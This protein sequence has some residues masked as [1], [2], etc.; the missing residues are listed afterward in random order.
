MILIFLDEKLL[1]IEEFLAIYKDAKQDKEQGSAEEYLECLSSHDKDKSGKL[2]VTTLSHLLQGY[3]M[4][5]KYYET[6]FKDR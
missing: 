2:S 6:H 1:S 4:C 5:S 3:G